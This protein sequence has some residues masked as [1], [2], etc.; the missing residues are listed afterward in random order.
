MSL[1]QVQVNSLLWCTETTIAVSAAVLTQEMNNVSS[2]TE[3]YRDVLKQDNTHVEAI[4]CIGSNHFYTDQPEI[5]L[6]FYRSEKLLHSDYTIH[7]QHLNKYLSLS[8]VSSRW[9]C[10]TVSCTTTWACAVSMLSSTT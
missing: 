10:T 3:Y 9:V 8:D 5:A 2:A 4:A 6:R 1:L 7:L